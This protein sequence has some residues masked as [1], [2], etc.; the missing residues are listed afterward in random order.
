MAQQAPRI[1]VVMPM[2]NGSRYVESAIQSVLGQTERSFELLICDDASTD[3]SLAIA[4]RIDDPR[5]RVLAHDTNRGLFPTLNELI[6]AASCELI[7]IWTQD[8]LMY[9]ECLERELAFHAEHPGLVMSYSRPH[10][11]DEHDTVIERDR[12]DTT[13]AVLTGAQA[14]ELMF[15]YGSISTNISLAV[16]RKSALDRVG[17]FRED[18]K[19]SGDFEM[20]TRLAGIGE[21]GFIHEPI[22]R[23]RTHL[24]QL[25][26]NP[27]SGLK[28]TRENREI[29][30]QLFERLP[31]EAKREAKRYQ[32]RQLLVSEAHAIVRN[33]MARDVSS[34]VEGLQLLARA[35]NPLPVFAWWLVSGNQRWLKAKPRLVTFRRAS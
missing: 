13:P 26:R 6:R 21:I 18:M 29:Y 33:V 22:A 14:S 11:I 12:H 24:G 1:S 16:V 20:W 35:D 19:V 3:G 34:A 31:A 5:V 15:Y 32:R 25:S 10:M 2:Y 17:L 9:P 4:R 23:V 28:F 30:R 8:D 7:H 27:A